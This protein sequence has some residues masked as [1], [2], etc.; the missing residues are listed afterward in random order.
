MAIAET[1]GRMGST[2]AAIVQTR[3]ELAA[4]EM[5]EESV[6]LLSY[7]ALGLLA[8][9]CASIAV[10]LL[11]FFIIVLFWD[12]YR[13]EAIFSVAVLFALAAFGIVLGVRNSYRNKP[14]MLSFTRAELR[15]DV[16]SMK[17]LGHIQ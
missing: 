15:K 16:A 3:L 1:L 7:L 8:L 11:A 13:L 17:S 9:L 14:G 5:E 4:L 12:T 10:T 2:L 6:R